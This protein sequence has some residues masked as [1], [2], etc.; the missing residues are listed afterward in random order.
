M[1]VYCQEMHIWWIV[2]F[3]WMWNLLLYSGADW[4][5]PQ[6]GS[7]HLGRLTYRAADH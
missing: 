4:V 1:G 6:Q 7:R 5:N 3:Q 2:L